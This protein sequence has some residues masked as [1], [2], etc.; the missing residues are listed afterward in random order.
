MTQILIRNIDG[1]VISAL[2][3]RAALSVTSM[4]EQAVKGASSQFTA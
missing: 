3:Q 1:A 2:R 4:Q